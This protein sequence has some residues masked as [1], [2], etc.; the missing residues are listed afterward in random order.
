LILH[1]KKKVLKKYFGLFLLFAVFVAQAPPDK[2]FCYKLPKVGIFDNIN[3]NHRIKR[4]FLC[5]I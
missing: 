5:L 3:I 2:K 4:G 1:Q